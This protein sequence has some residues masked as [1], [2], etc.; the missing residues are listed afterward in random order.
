MANLVLT[1]YEGS[2][3]EYRRAFLRKRGVTNRQ[4]TQPDRELGQQKAREFGFEPGHVKLA[5]I[6]PAGEIDTIVL[7]I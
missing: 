5:L 4:I 2:S 6:E 3:R 1:Q 7:T